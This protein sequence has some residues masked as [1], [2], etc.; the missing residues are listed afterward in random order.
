MFRKKGTVVLLTFILLSAIN[1][2]SYEKRK[3][4]ISIQPKNSEL[5]GVK[6][7]IIKVHADDLIQ[8]IGS[9]ADSDSVL[10][11]L[12]VDDKK[13]RQAS[14]KIEEHPTKSI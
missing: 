4:G 7:L 1:G 12:I 2:Y 3:N 11:S 9:P 8:I 13:L 14:F 5:T 10:M 6:Q